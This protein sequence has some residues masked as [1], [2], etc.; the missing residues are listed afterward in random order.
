[1]LVRLESRDETRRSGVQETLDPLSMPVECGAK[2]AHVVLQWLQIDQ[3]DLCDRAGAGKLL[4]SHDG[5]KLFRQVVHFGEI[6]S[7]LS[8][9]MP[10]EAGEALDNVGRIADLAHLA[11]ADICDTGLHLARHDIVHGCLHDTVEFGS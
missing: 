10:T 4:T 11:V 7:G 1:E 3:F 5:R 6:E 8:G 9:A 2:T